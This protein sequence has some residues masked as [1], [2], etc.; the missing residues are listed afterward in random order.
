MQLS[1][2]MTLCWGPGIWKAVGPP[3]CV[4]FRARGCFIGKEK[5]YFRVIWL[6]RARPWRAL[7]L[8]AQ[9]PFL[10]KRKHKRKGWMGAL[11]RCQSWGRRRKEGRPQSGG[12]ERGERRSFP[13][14]PWQ[15]TAQ[16][17]WSGASPPAPGSA[18]HRGAE[19]S[20]RAPWGAPH[21]GWH[22]CCPPYCCCCC[23][24]RRAEA[25]QVRLEAGQP[26]HPG[27]GDPSVRDRGRCGGRPL[28]VPNSSFAVPGR[29]ATQSGA[30]VWA[31]G[32]ES[33]LSI[34]REAPSTFVA[35]GARIPFASGVPGVQ[36]NPRW[37]RRLLGEIWSRASFSPPEFCFSH[38]WLLRARAQGH[39]S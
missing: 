16:P 30:R 5:R 33:L 28:F 31:P 24:S 37:R 36:G 34:P 19:R 27:T 1:A 10:K 18:L 15:Q 4:F 23:G 14:Q 38:G 8:G 11:S 13:A 21:C 20:A 35:R 29:W 26:P 7:A 25:S 32:G 22:C 12:R 39:S 6:A 3:V 17:P 2:Q 9:P